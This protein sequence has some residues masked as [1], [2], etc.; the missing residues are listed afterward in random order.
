M[1]D[2]K[3]VSQFKRLFR[4]ARKRSVLA[5]LLIGALIA[6]GGVLAFDYSM[7]AT[8]TDE[9]CVSC[10][11]QRDNSLVMFEQTAHYRNASGNH[12]SCSACHIPHEFGPKMLRKIQ[13]AREVW[14][15]LTGVIDTPEKYAAHAPAM[16]AREIARIRAND[17]QECRNCHDAQSMELSLQ[18]EKA[19]QFHQSVQ[20]D[21]VTC[22]DCHAGLAHDPA[23]MPGTEPSAPA[24]L[25]DHHGTSGQCVT[26]H[27]DSSGGPADDNLS[28]ENARCTGCHGDL[29]VLAARE[30][31]GKV[32][33][34][35]SHFIG[36]IACTTCHAGHEQSVNYCEACHSF[37]FDM[38]YGGP[39]T[40]EPAPLV[41]D[42]MDRLAQERAL[43]GEP[44][45]VTDVLVIGSGGAGMSAA[46]AAKEAGARVLLLEKEPVAG[47][48][49][50]LAAG[51][52]N[53]AETQAQA[54]LGIEDTVDSMVEDT[55]KGAYGTNDPA[56]VRILAQNSAGSI[57]WLEALG[58]D[59]SD[60]GRMG[61]ASVD[62]SHRPAGGAGVGAHVAQVLWDAV[63]ASGIDVRFNSRVVQLIETPSGAVTGVLVHGKYTGYYVIKAQAVIL[64]TG[65]F[66]RNNALVARYVPKLEGF[67]NTNQPGATGDGLEVAELAGAA[68]VDLDYI[69]AHPT[70]S[71]VGGVLVTEAVRG[72]GAILV[73]RKGE[74]FVNEITTRDKAA[75][76]I[77]AQPGGSAYLV[78]DDSV[79]RSLSKIESFVH[80]G[81]VEQ[82]RTLS[83]L[84]QTLSVPA[85]AL[86]RTVTDYNNMVGAG[87]DTLYQRPDLPR[88]LASAPYYAIEVTPAV[89]HTM[90]G[91][92]IDGRTRVVGVA[93]DAI[94]GL[95][96]A[97]EAAGG[98]HGANRLGANAVSDIITFGRLAGEQAARYARAD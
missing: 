87:S 94:A 14:A 28:H 93:G 75:A 58:A 13:A 10:H 35:H 59:L 21:D 65:G 69:Q 3:L 46:V 22:I 29:A 53:A 61:G 91:V 48:N 50:K 64:A 56:L 71:P 60:V 40:L 74:R 85:A 68:T 42:E 92:K 90:G 81:I 44:R 43:S 32:S 5:L 77:L 6:L 8:S 80:L 72:N 16:K 23:D 37:D 83:E 97:G 95:Y 15:H 19:R 49:T 20:G 45:S 31:D 78:F 54:R 66:S 30:P 41:A 52:M 1:S 96:A 82:G 27:V 98:I 57:A 39:W 84:A 79:R 2:S 25:A 17:S 18:S 47:G 88:A 76:A 34:H 73:N 63:V 24:V 12:V 7:Y 67:A 89:H 55:I 33:P 26:C 62:R 9:F 38:P 4:P 70:Y 86:T 51:G 36:E 11:E